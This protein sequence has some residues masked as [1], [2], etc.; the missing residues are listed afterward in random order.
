MKSCILSFLLGVSALML[1]S[2]TVVPDGPPPRA[3]HVLYEWYDDYGPGDVAVKINL[4]TQ[5][6]QITRGDRPIGWCYVATGKEGRGTP[7]GKY[8][9][10]EKIVDKYSN[11]YGWIEDEMGNTV[12]GDATPSS[13]VGPGE[14]YKPAPM[15]YWQ[16]LTAYGIGMHIGKIPQPGQPASHGCIRMPE[17]F[18]PLLFEVTKVGT[19]V[20]I[21][22]GAGESLPPLVDGLTME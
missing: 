18:K 8:K 6:A 14:V 4:T 1:P 22:Y 5:K 7:A 12:N 19:P 17:D 15:K 3:N 20:E 11:K 2:C 21:V 13:P 10:M 9:V 16:R